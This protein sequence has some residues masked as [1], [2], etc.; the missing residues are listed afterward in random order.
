MLPNF[1][2]GL[3]GIIQNEWM[4]EQKRS[5][6]YWYYPRGTAATVI[7]RRRE[8][9]FLS[10]KTFP[11]KNKNLIIT[12]DLNYSRYPIKWRKRQESSYAEVWLLAKSSGKEI[13]GPFMVSVKR[14]RLTDF[15]NPKWTHSSKLIR[16]HQICLYKD[17][18]SHSRSEYK[19]SEN[20]SAVSEAIFNPLQSFPSLLFYSAIHFVTWKVKSEKWDFASCS[21]ATPTQI[22]RRELGSEFGKCWLFAASCFLSVKGRAISIIPW[23]SWKGFQYGKMSN[24]NYLKGNYHGLN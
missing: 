5:L 20:V 1:D 3:L 8:I 4:N 11:M 13:F 23:V 18:S 19:F 10:R 2:H 14:R 6:G 15:I 12:V 24:L 16:R 17:D 22:G 21:R 9:F 7:N